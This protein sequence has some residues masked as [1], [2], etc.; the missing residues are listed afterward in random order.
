M[1]TINLP[2]GD[3]AQFPDGMSNADIEAVL[4]RQFPPQ[5]QPSQ[6]SQAYTDALAAGSAASRKFFGPP[7]SEQA[8]A[9]P[10]LAG[11]TAAT[12]AGLVNGIP[13]VG[14]A[15]QNVSDAI[16]G[17]GAQLTGG[18][19]G[20]T[21]RGLQRRREELAAANPIA[22]S[23]GN[24]ATMIAAPLGAARASTAAARGL[25][26]T[27]SLSQQAING[28]VSN[29]G[30]A[31]ADAA[32]RGGDPLASGAIGAIGGVAGPVVGRGV[33]AAIRGI[34]NNIGPTV[35]AA[36]DP[37]QEA[38]RRLGVAARRDRDA[39]NALT[40]V[41]EAAARAAGVP[42]TNAD[43][44][45]ET[46]R[47]LTRSVANQSPEARQAI[48]NLSE[49]RFLGQS[50][51]ATDF[52]RRV[53]GGAVDD[54]GLQN[55]LE[56]AA[57]TSNRPAYDA[58]YNAPA[59]RAIWNPR[60]SQLMQSDIFRGAVN[61]AESAGTDAAAIRGAR[62]VRN[63]FVFNPDGTVTLRTLPGGGRALPS[64]EFWDIVQRQLRRVNT[65]AARAG[66]DTLASTADQLRR[67]LNSELDGAVPQFQRARQGAYEFFQAE[68]ALEAGRNA[69]GST[70]SVPELRQAHGRMTQP[71]QDAA[72]VGY[73]SSLIDMI[74]SAR[75]RSNVIE[76]VFGNPARR[77]LN[78]IFLG[79]GRARQI[80]AYVRVEQL[81]D[82][83]RGALGNSTTARQLVELGIGGGAGFT[84]TGGDWKGALT[85]AAL[86]RGGRYLGER[87]DARVMEELARLLTS[88]NPTDLQRAINQASLSDQWMAGLVQFEAAISAGIKGSGL[89]V[90]ANQ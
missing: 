73:A 81:A 31:A 43:R 51:R 86:T 59:A 13:V 47:A 11:S 54:V 46:V 48:N 9:G 30:I 62:A 45:G 1:I 50:G 76:Q 69:V 15:I 88:R 75:D 29:A 20:E 7:T 83:L 37:V 58:A 77:E 82:R 41:D 53:M 17:T 8:P 56:F 35:Q 12:L 36:V 22:S 66:D 80:E 5:S 25:G 2:N 34:G 60:I 10:D 90:A 72:A 70:R 74:G 14:P 52:V 55:R 78:E 57:R 33:E 87:V 61:A 18:D 44:G 23:A 40:A 68:D 27:G 65:T 79:P 71:D 85:G 26:F 39:G 6:P 3:K 19:Y 64:L 42:L 28:A 38:F 32:V 84:L 67:A 16:V 89:A 24:I 63:P 49:D 4:A 21:V